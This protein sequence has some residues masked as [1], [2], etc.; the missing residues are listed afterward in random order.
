MP[1]LRTADGFV[2]CMETTKPWST[3]EGGDSLWHTH[4]WIKSNFRPLLLSSKT[5]S[6]GRQA[7]I[8]FK[9]IT[10]GRA[11]FKTG[12]PKKDTEGIVT[13]EMPSYL[14]GFISPVPPGR[15]RVETEAAPRCNGP[16]CLGVRMD[17]VPEPFTCKYPFQLHAGPRTLPFLMPTQEPRAPDGVPRRSCNGFVTA[18]FDPD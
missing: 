13:T 3:K 11:A 4:R 5:P 7:Q 14:T 2:K 16:R 15:Q 9:A 8:S 17:G 12:T 10:D 18:I 6:A 1:F